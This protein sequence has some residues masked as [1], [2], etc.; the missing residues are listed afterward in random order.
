M[1]RVAGSV[2][3][4]QDVGFRVSGSGFRVQGSGFRVQGL[5]LRFMVQELVS[6]GPIQ[7]CAQDPPDQ[8][9]LSSIVCIG[10]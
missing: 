7:G 2:F 3:R 1:F 10:W 4:V 8:Q 6:R 9:K 5:G